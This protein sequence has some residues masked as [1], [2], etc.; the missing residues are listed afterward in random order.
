MPGDLDDDYDDDSV[1][2]VRP[3]SRT[4]GRTR[5]RFDLALES[6][7][8]TSEAGRRRE[9]PIDAEH[10][11]IVELCERVRSVAEVA[12]LIGIPLGVARILLAD[13]AGVGLVIV[14]RATTPAGAMPDMAMMERVLSGLRRL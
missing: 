10:L 13:M 6:L 11:P 4:G 2:I 9:D 14:H 8:S 12:A 5:A 7:V 3:Y 1:S